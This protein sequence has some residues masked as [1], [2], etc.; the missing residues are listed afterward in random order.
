MGKGSIRKNYENTKDE[1]TEILK[2]EN[3][4]PELTASINALLK[5][6][7]VMMVVFMEKRVRKNS[8]NSGLPPSQDFSSN[9]NRNND[10]NK[11]SKAEDD[12]IRSNSK[13]KQEE[14][15]I[16]PEN[17][18]NCGTNLEDQEASKTEIRKKIDI[19]YETVEIDY[20]SEAKICPDCG[21]ENKKDFPL[22]IEGPIQYGLGIVALVIE[23]LMVQ[24]LSLKRAQEHFRGIIGRNISQ[25]TM[26]NYIIKFSLGLRD[27]ESEQIELILKSL[28]IHVDETSIR[29]NGRNWWVHTYSAGEIVLQFLHQS[30]GCEAID[31]IGIIPRY[32]GVIVHDCWA[33]YFTYG[34]V[35]HA[36]CLAHLLRELKYIE[37]ATG[38][39][40]ATRLK[41]LLTKA[42]KK[43]NDSEINILEKGQ[44]TRLQNTYRCILMEAFLE[45][46]PFSEPDGSRGRTKQTDEQNLWT[47]L[48][49]F[50]SSILMFARVAE[51]PAT[52]N[53]A[54][55]DLRSNKLKNKVSGCFR[56]EKMA[57]CY[58]R[59]TGYVKT[60]RNKG[61]SVA[62]SIHHALTLN[63]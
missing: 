55:R 46:P 25:A 1:I 13:A 47:R 59:I 28:V 26:L 14:V 21:E 51:V 20:I 50:E 3:V 9:G 24:M 38:H 37:E 53:R 16:A 2:N 27:W 49:N 44:Y 35:D 8:S 15:T 30:R 10:N 58:C 33:S 45:M 54:E 29:V 48:T 60:M 61:H 40:W 34:N 18:S 7:E 22:G 19:N 31:D 4:S 52:N 56:T 43:V 57:S 62:S 32:G 42:I 39:E 63:K 17:C 41:N 11:D 36:L 6:V 23:F 5:I 12:H